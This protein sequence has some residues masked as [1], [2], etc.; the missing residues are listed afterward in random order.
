M[1]F[2]NVQNIYFYVM[3]IFNGNNSSVNGTNAKV[4][5]QFMLNT[6]DVGNEIP[7]DI[8]SSLSGLSI[9]S[10]YNPPSAINGYRLITQS[11]DQ[12]YNPSHWV[13]A[14]QEGTNPAV[15]D[16]R[17]TSLPTTPNTSSEIFLIGGGTLALCITG[18]ALITMFDGTKKR[19]ED[20]K[21]G[22]LIL[23]DI[24]TN[25][26]KKVAKLLKMHIIDKLIIIPKNLLGNEHDIICTKNHPIWVN[27]DKNRI[28]AK[29]IIGTKKIQM[30]TFVY[31]IQYEEEGTFYAHGIK[32]DSVSP[33]NKIFK[34]QSVQKKPIQLYIIYY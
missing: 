31:N 15:N 20:I 10:S 21:R 18:D 6:S 17:T 25:N 24:N 3:S 11:G 2:N 14:F 4:Y 16:E 13:V 7:I 23:N 22:D 26:I 32:M 5:L 27:D 9:N 33:N 8:Y 1:S 28:S 34:L 29:Y 12:Q 30:N 19:I